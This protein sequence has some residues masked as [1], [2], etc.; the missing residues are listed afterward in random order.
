MGMTTE[1]LEAQDGRFR[2]RRSVDEDSWVVVDMATGNLI[3]GD[4]G[5]PEDQIL[6]RDWRW[7]PEAL[8]RVAEESA[9]ARA[10][11]ESAEARARAEKAEAKAAQYKRDWYAAKSEFGEAMAKARARIRELEAALATAREQR[12]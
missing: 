11:A 5:S 8:N 2:I 1:E 10:R 9:E 4:G 6:P 12:E 7:V 3:G